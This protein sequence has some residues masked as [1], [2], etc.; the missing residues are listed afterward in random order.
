MASGEGS[1]QT[2][3]PIL[4]GKNWDKLCIQMRVMF[5]Y[6]DFLDVVM[7][8]VANLQPNAT[9]AQ[10]KIHLE[11][12]KKDCKALFFIDQTVDSGIFEKIAR[13][14]IAKE[15]WE[16]LDKSYKGV[17]KIKKVRLQTLRRQFELLQMESKQSISE[18][19]TKILTLRV[20]VKMLKI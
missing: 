18:Y 17:K 11:H 5:G 16:I 6:Q 3:F 14:S 8:E 1:F 19:F 10:K 12:K 15:A 2:S 7:N 20:M 4:D 13:A 9:D